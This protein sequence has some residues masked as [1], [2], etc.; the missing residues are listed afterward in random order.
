MVR[1]LDPG[2]LVTKELKA[3][4]SGQFGSHADR[5]EMEAALTHPDE[6]DLALLRAEFLIQ[7]GRRPEAEV[8]W[9]DVRK[10]HAGTPAALE[11]DRRLSGGAGNPDEE[12][13][14]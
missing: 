5:R 9:R 11:A 1:W 10:K 8:I 7:L 14:Y 2:P 4:I 3:A 13:I 12:H 6:P